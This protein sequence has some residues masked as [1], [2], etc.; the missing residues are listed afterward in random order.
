MW[1]IHEFHWSGLG[2]RR[3]LEG[4]RILATLGR[5]INAG[6]DT[7]TRHYTLP[8]YALTGMNNT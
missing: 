6:M 2:G 1:E 7:T 4:T 5:E 3:V 8:S